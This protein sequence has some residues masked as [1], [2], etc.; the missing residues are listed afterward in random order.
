MRNPLAALG[1]IRAYF[2]KSEQYQLIDMPVQVGQSI[3]KHGHI[4][5]AHTRIQKVR[6]GKPPAQHQRSLFVDDEAAPAKSPKATRLDTFIRK[7]GGLANLA[8]L[9]A[10]MSESPQQHVFSEMGKMGGK[11]VAEVLA[12]FDNIKPVS[13]NLLK[14]ISVI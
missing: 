9:L 7:H 3:D 12:M 5:A 11:T 13:V 4:T 8:H 14:N 2:F 1:R 10:G 6:V